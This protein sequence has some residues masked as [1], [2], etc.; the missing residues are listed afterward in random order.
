MSAPAPP[1]TV[2]VNGTMTLTITAGAHMVCQKHETLT[3]AA[4][5]RGMQKQLWLSK[6]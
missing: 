2:D 5:E 3:D 4:K 1:V 6:T